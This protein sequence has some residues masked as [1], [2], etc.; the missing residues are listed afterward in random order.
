[1]N[2]AIKPLSYQGTI[3]W[4]LALG[5]FIFTSAGMGKEN[6]W[7]KHSSQ[8][9]AVQLWMHRNPTGQ[10]DTLRNQGKAHGVLKENGE[11]LNISFPSKITFYNMTENI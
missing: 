5:N 2:A 7:N 8:P 4:M 3:H 9:Q 11:A 10:P 6:S 1:M